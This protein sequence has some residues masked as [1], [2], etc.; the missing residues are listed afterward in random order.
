MS[1]VT[2][3][4]TDTISL[5]LLLFFSNENILIHLYMSVGLYF[6]LSLSPRVCVYPFVCVCLNISTFLCEDQNY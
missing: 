4:V 6:D 2:S 3:N 1:S 5:F